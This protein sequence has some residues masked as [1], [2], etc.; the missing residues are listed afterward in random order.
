[1]ARLPQLDDDTVQAGA[2]VGRGRAE[3]IGDLGVRQA[4]DELQGD[5]LA[6]ARLEVGERG[7]DGGALERVVLL[8][9]RDV[10]GLGDQR[11]EAPAPAQLVQRGVASDREQPCPLRPSA[12]VEGVA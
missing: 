3:D 11:R 8:V 1:M 2:G 9:R 4:G 5:E 6:I 7:P 10:D 12:P